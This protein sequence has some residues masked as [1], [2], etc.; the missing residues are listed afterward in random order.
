MSASLGHGVILDRR[1]IA[2]TNVFPFLIFHLKLCNRIRN[3]NCN[4]VQLLEHFIH[5]I[6]VCDIL[7]V[8]TSVM[9]PHNDPG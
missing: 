8:V 6:L 9:T 5:L 2:S 4:K 7:Y 1:V 3:S